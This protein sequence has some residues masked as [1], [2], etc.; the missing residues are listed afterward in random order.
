MC[1]NVCKIVYICIYVPFC[2][3]IL[4]NIFDFKCTPNFTIVDTLVFIINI[5]N[6]MMS[7]HL[8]LRVYDY[9]IY[10]KTLNKEMIR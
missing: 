10:D 9:F 4:S 2:Y 1:V 6:I 8:T 3:I 7:F 5:V